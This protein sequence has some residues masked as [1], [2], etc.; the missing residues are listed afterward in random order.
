MAP[1]K[2]LLSSFFILTK[3]LFDLISLSKLTRAFLPL[4]CKNS[5]TLALISKDSSAGISPELY[6]TS[7]CF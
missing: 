6:K 3:D 5:T 1:G 4:P 2:Q 7:M